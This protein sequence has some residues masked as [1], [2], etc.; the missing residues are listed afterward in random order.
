MGVMMPSMLAIILVTSWIVGIVSFVTAMVMLVV[1]A[2]STKREKRKAG[3]FLFYNPANAI[4]V[5]DMLTERGLRA[6]RCLL[7][8][9]GIA[10]LNFGAAMAILFSGIWRG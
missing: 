8:A 2:F 9:L 5:S 4:F 1:I 6:R 10:A 3:G 7:V